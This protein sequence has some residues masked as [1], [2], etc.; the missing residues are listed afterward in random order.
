[1]KNDLVLG[2]FLFGCWT[3]F[4][5]GPIGTIG[6]GIWLGM[7]ITWVILCFLGI[8]YFF[9]NE[10]AVKKWGKKKLPDIF[11]QHWQVYNLLALVS[12]SL[13][14]EFSV[15][16]LF[17]LTSVVFMFIVIGTQSANKK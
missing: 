17:L 3:K 1:M 4:I 8:M 16:L 2:Y 12:Y 9:T 5:G 10:D 15:S 13:C 11:I 6:H 7:V 14:K